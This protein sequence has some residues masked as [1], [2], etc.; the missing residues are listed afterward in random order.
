MNQSR[1]ELKTAVFAEKLDECVERLRK[2]VQQYAD[3]EKG[4]AV[5][6]RL[7]QQLEKHRQRGYLSVAF[8]GQYSAGKSSTIA[9]LTGRA[10]INIDT[11]IATDEVAEFQWNHVRLIDTPGLY[12][13]RPD[14]DATTYEALSQAD[15]VVY[16]L[17]YA[18]FDS[19]T[20]QDFR[21]LAFEKS[22]QPK[23]LLLVN[24]ANCEAGEWDERIA[25]YKSSLEKSLQ[26]HSL[27]EFPVCFADAL[28]YWEGVE[29]DDE[30]LIEDSRFESFIEALNQFVEERGIYGQLDTPARIVIE[31]VDEAELLFQRSD[32]QDGAYL[33]QLH[34]LK[35]RNRLQRER[36]R[37]KVRDICTRLSR[38]VREQG[39]ALAEA[40]GGDEGD[41]EAA[42]GNAQEAVQ[43]AAQQANGEL[44]QAVNGV[45]EE[46]QEEF[47]EVLSGPL[48][49]QFV[50][51][52]TLD[53]DP[54]HV[55]NARENTGDVERLKSQV[56]TL[57]GIGQKVGVKV[58]EMSLNTTQKA[59]GVSLRATQV[60]GSQMHNIVL[61]VG[62]LVGVKFKPWQAVN[63]AGKI[64]AAA[65]WLGPAA[66][67]LSV[68]AEV[69][70]A[71]Q[72]N[73]QAQKAASARHDSRA[74]FTSIA[75]E[76]KQNF[77]SQ[78]AQIEAETFDS[79][80]A[81]IDAARN[82]QQAS[83]EGCSEAVGEIRQV[84]KDVKALLGSLSV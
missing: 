11:D 73:E 8:V 49:E 17:T 39:N 75:S 10:D 72:E 20:L 70:S 57:A 68:G 40:I 21:R 14:H 37:S 31:S 51:P 33:Q 44:E 69:Y 3:K 2:I 19:V 16:T 23:M 4:Q 50:K 84:K 77:E 26:P 55:R 18:L 79:V 54:V 76:L 60:S 1:T 48:A 53:N 58:S 9:S 46:L 12:T 71:V 5:L 22:L 13:E 32:T 24:K 82:A 27:S 65:R 47:R 6:D 25:N 74:Q 66:A 56:K 36:L 43:Q 81:D 29:D 30:E 83:A 38:E 59:L 41:A 64:G 35:R 61:N 80:D 15:L 78:L 28:D 52:L 34:Q 7:E 42:A 45:I 63:V 62:H 67:F